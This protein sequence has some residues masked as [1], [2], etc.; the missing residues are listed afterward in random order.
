MLSG[1][2]G[3]T[4]TFLTQP[5]SGRRAERDTHAASETHGGAPDRVSIGEG[6][7]QGIER[8]SQAWGR[9]GGVAVGAGAGAGLLAA[10]AHVIHPAAFTLTGGPVGIMLAGIIVTMA[11]GA[12]VGYRVGGKAMQWIG[13]AGAAVARKIGVSETTGRRVAKGAAALAI[14][15]PAG[16]TLAALNIP[17]LAIGVGTFAIGAAFG[18]ARRAPGATAGSQS[19]APLPAPAPTAERG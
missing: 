15:A 6:A 17:G 2:L 11:A 14:A 5:L 4:A 12:Y 9:L 1:V 18:A 8:V 16:L 19:A 3:R 10:A 7:A 13:K